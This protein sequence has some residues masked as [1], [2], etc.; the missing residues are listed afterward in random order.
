MSS[1]KEVIPVIEEDKKVPE[2]YSFTYFWIDGFGGL[3]S[4]NFISKDKEPS[5]QRFDGSATK[6]AATDNSDLFLVPIKTYGKTSYWYSG[7]GGYVLCEVQTADGTPHLSNARA[8]LKKFISANPSL[9]QVEVAFE[10]EFV[11][12]DPDTRQPYTWPTNKNE[13]GEVTTVFPGPQGRYYGGHGDFVRGRDIVDIFVNDSNFDG[14]G[15]ES[16]MPSIMLSQWSFVTTPNSLLSACDDLIF[17]R[18][19]LERTAESSSKPR[20][21]VSYVPK[22]FPGMEWNG[23]ACNF[24]F[25]LPNYGPNSSADPSVAKGICEIL[26]DDHREHMSAYG[27]GNEQRLV[28]KS[29]GVSDYNKFSWGF[30]DRTASV[31]VPTIPT[32]VDQA[33]RFMYIEDRR[34]GANVDPYLGILAASRSLVK[35]IAVKPSKSDKKAESFEPK[36]VN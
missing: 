27:S 11:L 4:A 21:V 6:Q 29:N 36:L 12:I 1:K 23:S 13:K 20:A 14:A 22:S 30:G 5:I 3:R 19:L 18:F 33:H 16:Y 34:P 8:D 24:R 17:R 10:Q 2:S 26:A 35:A 28:G 31:C 25:Y 15:I 9:N 32:K 7:N